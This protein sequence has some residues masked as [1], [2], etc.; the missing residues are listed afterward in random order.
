[1]GFNDQSL[2]RIVHGT[3]KAIHYIIS[4]MLNLP[5]T[6]PDFIMRCNNGI[7]ILIWSVCVYN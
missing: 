5:I 7:S 2:N 4:N 3:E 1:M 6:R